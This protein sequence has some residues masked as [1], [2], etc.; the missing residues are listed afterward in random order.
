MTK[1]MMMMAATVSLSACMGDSTKLSA[2]APINAAGPMV[3]GDNPYMQGAPGMP[4]RCGPQ[5][6]LYYTIE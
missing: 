3:C 2:T 1:Y 5:A 6:E 4:V